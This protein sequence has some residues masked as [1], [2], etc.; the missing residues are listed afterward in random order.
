MYLLRD[1]LQQLSRFHRP[2]FQ[3]GESFVGPG[4]GDRDWTA[5]ASGAECVRC[6]ENGGSVLENGGPRDHRDLQFPNVTDTLRD[7]EH[8]L[9]V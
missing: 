3:A 2:L 7:C 6:G 9:V 4:G 1:I 5:F 8:V